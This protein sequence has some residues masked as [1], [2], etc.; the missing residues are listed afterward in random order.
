MSNADEHRDD[1]L[2]NCRK[3]R[4]EMLEYHRRDALPLTAKAKWE[5][6]RPD[7][8]VPERQRLTQ[9]KLEYLLRPWRKRE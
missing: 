8:V 5:V 9:G 4:P 3:I 7:V 2:S 1:P 6:L